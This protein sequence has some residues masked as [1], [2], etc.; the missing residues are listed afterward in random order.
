MTSTTRYI[1]IGAGLVLAQWVVLQH[2]GIWGATP[3]VVLLFLA[4]LALRVSRRTAAL[5]GFALGFALDIAYGTWGMHALVKT[6]TGFLL[7]SVTLSDDRDAVLIQ[8]NQAFLGGFLLTLMHNGLLVILLA[9]QAQTSNT[10][11]VN[12]LWLGSSLYTAVIATLVV[13]LAPRDTR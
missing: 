13:W 6:I 11:L 7:G 12:A 2:L 5:S 8:P 1:L 9:L 4:W 3:D 10:F